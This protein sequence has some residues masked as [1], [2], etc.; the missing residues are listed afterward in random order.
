M[1][2]FGRTMNVRCKRGQ[3]GLDGIWIEVNSEIVMRYDFSSAYR[4]EGTTLVLDIKE[5]YSPSAGD[6]KHIGTTELP[7]SFINICWYEKDVDAHMAVEAWK[8]YEKHIPFSKLTGYLVA[9]DVML[10]KIWHYL[11]AVPSWDVCLTLPLYMKLCEDIPGFESRIKK[12]T[13]IGDQIR[14]S[15][16]KLNEHLKKKTFR[17]QLLDNLLEKIHSLSDELELA[18][19]IKKLGYDIK[20]GDVEQPDYF[21]NDFPAE[22]KSRFPDI[23]SVISIDLP[24]H[25][26]YYKALQ[27]LVFEIK[28]T[29]KG[30]KKAEIYFNNLSRLVTAMKFQYGVEMT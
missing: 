25:F 3:Y 1:G 9:R 7:D 2:K 14:G 18:Y 19:N 4:I 15:A 13:E 12:A 22:H 10:G 11:N 30:L 20:F 29:K 24:S 8:E 27:E 26:D 28:G 6:F 5:S 16:E 21:I 23:K 17:P